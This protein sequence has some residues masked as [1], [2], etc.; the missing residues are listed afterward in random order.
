MQRR[1]FGGD[2][3]GSIPAFG[4][5]PGAS[6]AV[7]T[8]DRW[9]VLRHRTNPNEPMS[10]NDKSH[11]YGQARSAFDALKMDE[12]AAFLVESVVAML[13]EGVG[14]AGRVVS[15]VIDEMARGVDACC[16]DDAR[17]APE[18]DAAPAAKATGAAKRSTGKASAKTGSRRTKGS[19][20]AS[21]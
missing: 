9:Y 12:R 14:E 18:G 2:A 5:K 20:P 15:E 11:A 17:T 7:Y 8:T 1:W 19:A 3:K 4:L 21:E 13:A 10:E 6:D 16:D